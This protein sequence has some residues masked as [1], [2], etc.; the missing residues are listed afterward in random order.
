MVRS[1]RFAVYFVYV[2]Q[3]LVQVAFSGVY[4][5][6][7]GGVAWFQSEWRVDALFW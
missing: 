7:Y 6:F 2:W 5:V 4:V 3:L 1:R